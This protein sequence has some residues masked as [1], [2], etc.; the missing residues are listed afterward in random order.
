VVL[1]SLMARTIAVKHD[2][3]HHKVNGL[4]LHQNTLG[5]FDHASLIA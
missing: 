3:F 2:G 5:T 1:L 4:T